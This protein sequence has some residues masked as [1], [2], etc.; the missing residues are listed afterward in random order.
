MFTDEINVPALMGPMADDDDDSEDED[1][2]YTPV[3]KDSKSLM[4]SPLLHL[5]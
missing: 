5:Y 3:R 4:V 1:D 2:D